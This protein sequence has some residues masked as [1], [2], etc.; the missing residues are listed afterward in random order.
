MAVGE[1]RELEPG[2]RGSQGWELVGTHRCIWLSNLGL[3]FLRGWRLRRSDLE[4]EAS[5]QGRH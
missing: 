3:G 1:L 4:N 2:R 5:K